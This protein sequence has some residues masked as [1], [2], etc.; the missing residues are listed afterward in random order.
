MCS[1][2]SNWN[3]LRNDWFDRVSSDLMRLSCCV[4][5]GKLLE[6]NRLADASFNSHRLKKNNSQMLICNSYRCVSCCCLVKLFPSNKLTRAW[7]NSYRLQTTNILSEFSWN[8]C[9]LDSNWLIV[10][11]RCVFR[12]SLNDKL[13]VV[14][15]IAHQLKR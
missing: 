12:E 13:E 2:E 15:L 7:I 4:V 11:V 9:C 14:K 5:E 6:S 8:D 3:F 10:F 1:L